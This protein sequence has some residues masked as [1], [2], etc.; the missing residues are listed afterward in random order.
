[1]AGDSLKT[2]KKQAISSLNQI[3]HEALQES[4]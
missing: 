3:V 1:M 2:E 4:L